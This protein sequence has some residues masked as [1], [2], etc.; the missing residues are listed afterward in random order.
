VKK[1]VRFMCGH[2]VQLHRNHPPSPSCQ[3]A[4]IELGTMT[5]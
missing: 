2:K 1:H 3:M 5:Q 4:L